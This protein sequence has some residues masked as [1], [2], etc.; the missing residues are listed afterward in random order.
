[1]ILV[2]TSHL[3]SSFSWLEIEVK[4]KPCVASLSLC[5][6]L[7]NVDVSKPFWWAEPRDKSLCHLCIYFIYILLVGLS[8]YLAYILCFRFDLFRCTCAVCRDSI[9]T[10]RNT[11]GSRTPSLVCARTRR[12]ALHI[13][14]SVCVKPVWPVSVLAA[15]WIFISVQIR[16]FTPLLGDIKILSVWELPIHYYIGGATFK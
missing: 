15:G 11:C 14:G 16:L 12:G 2:E 13:V 1:V 10:I 4:G 9:D 3:K 7:N 8:L 5:G 6:Y